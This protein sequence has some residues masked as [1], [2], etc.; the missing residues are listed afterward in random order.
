M[1]EPIDFSKIAEAQEEDET[2][3]EMGLDDFKSGNFIKNP[4]VGEVLTFKVKKVV[5]NKVTTGKNKTT[6]KEFTIGLEDKNKRVKRIDIVTAEDS[7]YTVP[8]WGIYFKL[9]ENSK[10]LLMDYARKHSNSFAGATVSIKKL[11]DASH[12]NVKAEDLAKILGKS[13]QEALVY[14]EAIKQA[15]KNNTL[16]EVEVK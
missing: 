1:A 12:A 10:G 15:I 16:Y 13:T 6:G 8:N 4:A 2:A 3:E 14:Q 7:V 11:L 5:N 9:F